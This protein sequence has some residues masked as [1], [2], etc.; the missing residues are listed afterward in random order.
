MILQLKYSKF[1]SLFFYYNYW[2]IKEKVLCCFHFG[3]VSFYF[4]L[5][6]MLVPL[7]WASFFFF[8]SSSS[9]FFFF[10]GLSISLFANYNIEKNLL[11]QV[12][13]TIFVSNLFMLCLFQSFLCSVCMWIMWWT[14]P[15][16][17]IPSLCQYFWP[18]LC[19]SVYQI[20]TK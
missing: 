13:Y 7:I 6:F 10:F 4:F 16:N 11:S 9:S 12:I 2:I 14:V 17:W 18:S 20:K 3:L 8:F 5:F 1:K 15:V 19:M